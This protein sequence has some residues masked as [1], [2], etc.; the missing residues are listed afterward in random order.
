MSQAKITA[1]R[2][3]QIAR[4][5]LNAMGVDTSLSADGKELRGAVALPAGLVLRHPMREETVERIVFRVLGHDRL[6]LTEPAW[7]ASLDPQPFYDHKKFKTVVEQLMIRLKRRVEAARQL[8]RRLVAMGFPSRLDEALLHAEVLLVL[9]GQG[10]MLL[11]GDEHGLKVE[12]F[13]SA[14]PST[15]SGHFE[16]WS[17]DL[18]AFEDKADLEMALIQ[19]LP[20]RLAARVPEKEAAK[21]VASR[22]APALLVLGDL[23]QRFGGDCLVASGLTLRKDLQV[24]NQAVRFLAKHRQAGQF[25]GRL[26]TASGQA[27]KGSFEMASFVSVEDFVAGLMGQASVQASP[28]PR[29]EP[30]PASIA[31]EPLDMGQPLPVAGE[32]WVMTALL[33]GDDGREIRYVGVDLDGAPFGAPRILPREAFMRIFTLVSHGVYRLRVEVQE[34]TASHISYLQLDPEGKP[35]LETRQS[36]PP[37]FLSSFVPEA[38]GF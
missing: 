34:V 22:N 7:M 13:K 14:M 37:A 29:A 12:A 10:R 3:A 32:I 17:V 9:P 27:W 8:H 20:E 24:G 35:S 5:K 26:D 15:P 31:A 1:E 18:A 38:A 25:D 19:E 36:A 33:E 4:R 11:I 21:P 23:A 30:V 16:G 6:V 28:P 2:L